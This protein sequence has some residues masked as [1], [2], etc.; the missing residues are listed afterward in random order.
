MAKQPI[1]RGAQSHAAALPVELPPRPKA[2]G[3]ANGNGAGTAKDIPA[4][5]L[6]EKTPDP[7]PGI[8][9]ELSFFFGGT[10]AER[11]EF[12][13]RTPRAR[14]TQPWRL[15]VAGPA[16]GLFR[17]VMS[18][19]GRE[20]KESDDIETLLEF[21]KKQVLTV[22]D[23]IAQLVLDFSP[24]LRSREDEILDL[25][26]DE[27]LANAFLVACQV[28][29]PLSSIQSLLKIGEQMSGMSQN[30]RSPNGESGTKN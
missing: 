4:P 16:E 7:T 25:A 10:G 24:N 23:V 15:A 28:A 12:K 6:L 20:F 22:P 5:S 18:M 21:V 1:R 14:Q 13:F 11:K 2:Q 3:G 8:S 29:F 17:G 19:I 27:E 9:G 26:F 30:S